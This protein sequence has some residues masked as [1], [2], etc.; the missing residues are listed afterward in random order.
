MSVTAEYV[1]N[2]FKGLEEGDG[3][4]FFSHVDD[5]VDWIVQGTHPLAGHYHSKAAFIEG[6]FTKLSKVLPKGAQLHVENLLVNGDA[7]V[8]ELR[9]LATAKNGLR[10]DNRYCWI[11]YFQN[12]VIA[13]VRAYLDSAM[14][15]RLFEEN[16]IG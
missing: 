7:A 1:S 13:R 5:N 15:A 16:P 4:S 9:S 14:V 3:A 2:I 6:T 11:V 8:V 10:F 12:D